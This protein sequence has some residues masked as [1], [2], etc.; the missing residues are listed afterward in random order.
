MI[1]IVPIALSRETVTRTT[2]RRAA[3]S[4]RPQVHVSAGAGRAL[5]A[6]AGLILATRSMGRFYQA[7]DPSIALQQ[8]GSHASL[9]A[10]AA[11][12][13]FKVLA[14]I[15]GPLT[16]RLRPDRA[17]RLGAIAYAV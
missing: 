13:S 7:F 14:L 15:G 9:T 17:L 16:A 12:G 1:A 5:L 8:L 2:V 4:L 3:A 6:M 11:F 10:G